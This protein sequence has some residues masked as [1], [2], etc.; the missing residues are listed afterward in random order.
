MVKYALYNK[1]FK[2]WFIGHNMLTIDRNQARI[3]NSYL[4]AYKKIKY[5]NMIQELGYKFNWKVVKIYG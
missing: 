4:Q 3:F 5:D 1:H 2:V